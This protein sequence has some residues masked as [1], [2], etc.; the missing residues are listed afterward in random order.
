MLGMCDGRCRLL[1]ESRVVWRDLW[2][3]FIVIVLPSLT[4]NQNNLS[5]DQM[6]TA[7]GFELG[8]LQI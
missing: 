1:S 2:P 8:C 3:V 6:H 5:F 7:Q 4:A